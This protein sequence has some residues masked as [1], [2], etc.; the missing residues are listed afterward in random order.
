MTTR[1]LL[2]LTLTLLSLPAFAAEPSKQA[3]PLR[4]APMEEAVPISVGRDLLGTVR[5]A[6]RPSGPHSLV[7]VQAVLN[8]RSTLPRYYSMQVAIFDSAQRLVACG[9]LQEIDTPVQPNKS[10]NLSM[11][12]RIPNS[13]TARV[14]SYQ[15]TY[16]E[17]ASPALE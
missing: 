16:Y 5:I 11:S 2:A 9:S 1:A 8:N 15:I 14:S 4:L 6:T 17:A 12:M 13:A 7:L 3:G 10:M